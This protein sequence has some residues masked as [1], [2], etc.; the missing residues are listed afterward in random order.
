MQL[1]IKLYNDKLPRVGIVYPTE[2]QAGRAFEPYLAE[3]LYENF[4]MSIELLK[5]KAVLTLISVSGS[6]RVHYK[7]L[8]FKAEEVK[9]LQAYVSTNAKLEF[10]HTY[11]KGNTLMIAKVRFKNP[12]PLTING[13]Q[14]I[15][16][17]NYSGALSRF[18]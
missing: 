17:E 18:S 16:P 1:A 3:F 4:T 14:L 12:P 13:Y 7:D 8:D 9:K 5:G 15:V 2:F 11:W 6:A 10:I